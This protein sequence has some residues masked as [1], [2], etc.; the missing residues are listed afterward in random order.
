MKIEVANSS[1][2]DY[3]AR[4]PLDERFSVLLHWCEWLLLW[5]PRKAGF[6]DAHRKFAA[7]VR[8]MREAEAQSQDTRDS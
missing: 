3:Y 4:L 8:E 7:T 2:A 1:T 6:A 5:E